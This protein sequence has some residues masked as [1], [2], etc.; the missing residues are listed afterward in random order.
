[1]TIQNPTPS[2]VDVTHVKVFGVI[3]AGQMGLGIA[4]VAAQT[5]HDVLIVDATPELAE[6]GRARLGTSLD[7]LVEKGR[8][9]AKERDAILSRVHA[10]K[11]TSELFAADIVVEAATENMDL[12]IK[13]FQA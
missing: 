13:I 12:K 3:G 7:R 5:G 1:M 2:T 9:E 6:K 11:S 10:C 4:Q 8:M